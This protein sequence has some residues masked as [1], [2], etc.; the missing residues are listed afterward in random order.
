MSYELSAPS[1]R[2]GAD[3]EPSESY[4]D[5]VETGHAHAEQ[6]VATVAGETSSRQFS[7]MLTAASTLAKH[8]SENAE[9][10]FDVHDVS[11]FLNLPLT[12]AHGLIDVLDVLEVRAWSSPRHCLARAAPF[13][14]LRISRADRNMKH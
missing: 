4:T 6:S 9:D 12:A 13:A 1:A 7:L 5:V 2:Y 8:C 3:L 14:R 11:A 10:L